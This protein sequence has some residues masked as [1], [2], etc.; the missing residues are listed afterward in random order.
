MTDANATRLRDAGLRARLAGAIAAAETWDREV[1]RVRRID[2]PWT[3]C[4]FACSAQEAHDRVR[5]LLAE[6]DRLEEMCGICG[7]DPADVLDDDL[8]GCCAKCATR[9]LQATADER[10]EFGVAR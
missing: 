9:E 2:D 10:A 4:M 3:R 1:D 8:R 5:E 7:E 6:R